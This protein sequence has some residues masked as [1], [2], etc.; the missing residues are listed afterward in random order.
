MTR[1]HRVPRIVVKETRV[2]GAAFEGRQ[3][4]TL[5]LRGESKH[6]YLSDAIFMTNGTN[7]LIYELAALP[8]FDGDSK[9]LALR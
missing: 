7:S 5:N 8:E 4:E 3:R 9:K 6:S 2:T 1:P